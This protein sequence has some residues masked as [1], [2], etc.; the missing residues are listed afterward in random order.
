MKQIISNENFLSALKKT[1]GSLEMSTKTLR[2]ET[3]SLYTIY[4]KHYGNTFF[5]KVA[6]REYN[7]LI[8]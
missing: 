3:T 4:M 8:Q 6:T 1:T 5:P 7:W 2:K